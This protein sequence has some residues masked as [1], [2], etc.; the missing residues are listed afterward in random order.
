MGRSL[1]EPA[2]LVKLQALASYGSRFRANLNNAKLRLAGA[3]HCRITKT[4]LN[5]WAL[6]WKPVAA[7][8]IST[9]RV[10]RLL[11]YW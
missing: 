11:S 7:N 2:L 4:R 10:T 9:S 3:Y 8:S 1:T 6:N 5:A